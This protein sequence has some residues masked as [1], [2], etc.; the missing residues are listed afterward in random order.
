MKP[1][2]KNTKNAGMRLTQVSYKPES[3]ADIPEGK[4]GV[5]LAN[6]GTP[7]GHDYWSM[8]RYLHE[9]L[10]D[11]RVINLP[12]W[13]WQPL[14]QMVILT[15]RPFR[16]G[17]AYREIWN[18]E[19]NEGPLTTIT[20]AKT[21]LVRKAISERFGDDVIVEYAMR[22]GSPPVRSVLQKMV[23]EGCD[24]VLFFPLY[25]QY[26]GATTAT[27]NDAFFRALME[28]THQPAT[29]TVP[30]YYD[31]ASYVDTLAKS[32]TQA[33]GGAQPDALVV[34]YHGMPQSYLDAGDP[35][36][37]QCEKTTQLL[38]ERLG[39]TPDRVVSSYQ[40]RFGGAEWL[41]P[42]SVDKVEELA[43]AGKRNIAILAPGFS[44][45]CL[46][47]LEEINGEIRSAFLDA[48]GEHFTYI[49]CLNSDAAHITMLTGII[50]ENLKGWLD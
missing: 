22:Y 43:R 27:A 24:R 4:V 33:L 47:T 14:L 41:K 44:A 9:F 36:Y 3:R 46:E 26:A 40:S 6:L 7:D 8:R 5:L 21:N 49:P 2:S 35:Y 37:Y 12:R 10:S 19:H 20:R 11:K 32:V 1:F 42:Y 29:R 38:Q 45:D 23:S 17:T 25:P 13:R 31:D 50:A 18:H 39:W 30:A 16:S 15:I 34:S 28:E 48:G